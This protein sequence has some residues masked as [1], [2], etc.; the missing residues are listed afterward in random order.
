MFPQRAP[1]GTVLLTSFVGGSRFKN[2]RSASVEQLNAMALA[3]LKRLLG[4]K[5]KPIFS[6]HMVWHDAFPELT[7][8]YGGVLE[9]M[10]KIE[11]TTPF[12]Y[13]AG[14]HRD[15]LAV[16]KA[17]V[18][19]YRAAERVLADLEATGGRHLFTMA[20]QDSPPVS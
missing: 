17:L 12:F 15:G 1:K 7:H 3:D 9:S 6:S 18:G 2:L 11:A 16:G 4:V 5:A 8:G 13:W 19:G 20:R 14:N 10:R